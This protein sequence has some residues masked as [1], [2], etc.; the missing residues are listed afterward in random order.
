[1]QR[2]KNEK[3]E[4]LISTSSMEILRCRNWI[5]KW[6]AR[7]RCRDVVKNNNLNEFTI[8]RDGH[9]NSR[10]NGML[11]SWNEKKFKEYKQTRHFVMKMKTW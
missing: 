10:G 5:H 11:I 8:K 7:E 4:K 2:W 1:M 6:I 9:E 3:V